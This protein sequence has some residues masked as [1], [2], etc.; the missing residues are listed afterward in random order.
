MVKGGKHF[1]GPGF[2]PGLGSLLAFAQGEGW[3]EWNPQTETLGGF[4]TLYSIPQILIFQVSL[5][6]VWTEK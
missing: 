3:G 6:C 4:Y 1:G 5:K 2:Q